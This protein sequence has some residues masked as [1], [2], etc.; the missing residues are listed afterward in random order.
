MLVSK[1]SKS[2]SSNSYHTSSLSRGMTCLSDPK[3]KYLAPIKTQIF[4]AE[5]SYSNHKTTKV[6]I[7]LPYAMF[8][9]NETTQFK[10]IP[11]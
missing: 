4:I 8:E 9:Y 5:S 1:I 7:H 6:Q 3:R 11:L 10:N 2:S